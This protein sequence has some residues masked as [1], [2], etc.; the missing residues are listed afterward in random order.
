MVGWE[1]WVSFIS[2]MTHVRFGLSKMKELRRIKDLPKTVLTDL[3]A[4]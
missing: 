3:V 1:W 4:L 2:F